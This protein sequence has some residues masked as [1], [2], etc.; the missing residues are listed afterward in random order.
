ML[1]MAI[2]IS[3]IIPIEEFS[4]SEYRVLSYVGLIL[5]VTFFVPGVILWYR[6]VGDVMSFERGQRKALMLS[7]LLCFFT[8]GAMIYWAK[9]LG[10]D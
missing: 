5:S 1:L 7:L 6:A 2:S 10:S 4:A 9:E 3:S 8:F